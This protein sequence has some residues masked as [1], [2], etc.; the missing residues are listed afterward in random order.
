[1]QSAAYRSPGMAP[2]HFEALPV[3]QLFI[4]ADGDL[5]AL[6]GSIG[7]P[8]AAT[9]HAR[10]VELVESPI[11]SCTC[12]GHILGV[13]KVYDH[14]PARRPRRR[15]TNEPVSI[16]EKEYVSIRDGWRCTY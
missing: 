8:R 10:D 15:Y 14:R 4:E 2:I 16:S 1:M 7:T 11:G 5:A 13:R 3:L 9:A 12:S 6:P